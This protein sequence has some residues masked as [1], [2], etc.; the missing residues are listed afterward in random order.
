MAPLPCLNASSILRRIALAF[1]TVGLL[2]VGACRKTENDRSSA[3]PN[4]IATA[5]GNAAVIDPNHPARVRLQGRYT[6]A[7]GE[8]L[9]GP[10]VNAINTI[11]APDT[12]HPRPYAA[13]AR[14]GVLELLLPGAS[15]TVVRIS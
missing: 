10:A 3:K 8:T 2:A 1:A 11:A 5:S 13:S 7:A 6:Q 14:N 15:V 9:T 4:R 12:V